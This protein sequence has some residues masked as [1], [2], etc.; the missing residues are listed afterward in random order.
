MGYRFKNVGEKSNN[1]L[2]YEWLCKNPLGFTFTIEDLPP[3]FPVE[4][5]KISAICAF[6]EK[7]GTVETIG[8]KQTLRKGR[9]GALIV[10]DTRVYKFLRRHDGRFNTKPVMS[11]RKPHIRKTKKNNREV[12]AL[13]LIGDLLPKA[14]DKRIAAKAQSMIEFLINTAS[15]IEEL[16]KENERLRK[17]INEKV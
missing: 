6:F 14:T 10:Y 7:A 12:N 2:F 16:V 15:V 11:E 9:A 8:R 1:Q 13:P 4:K 5:K 3:D 17:I